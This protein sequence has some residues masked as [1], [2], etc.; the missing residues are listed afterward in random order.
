[1]GHSGTIFGGAP[2]NTSLVGLYECK[3][4]FLCPFTPQD[5]NEYYSACGDQRSNHL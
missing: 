2:G 4:Y 1:M 5:F 3:Y